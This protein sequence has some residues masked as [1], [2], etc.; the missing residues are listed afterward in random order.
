LE[1]SILEA[2][3]NEHI[4]LCAGIINNGGLVAFPTE[5]VYGLGANAFDENAVSEIFRIKGR[6]QDNP[7]I[8]HV[9]S[10][11]EVEVLV[12]DTPGTFRIIAEAF[13]PGPLT[14]V[15]KKNAN[16]P[17]ITTA[18]LDIVAIRMPEHPAALALIRAC[19]KPLA[20][21]SA[22]PSGKPSPTKAR[23]VMNDLKGKI[24]YILDGGDCRVG[25]ESTVLD[26]VNKRPRIL[27]PGGVTY[28]ELRDVLSDVE[29]ASPV[30]DKT[31]RSP[32]MKYRHYAPKA[33]L[34]VVLGPPGVTAEYIKGQMS[35][36]TAALMFDD[37]RLDDPSVVTFGP[38]TDLSTQ[39]NRLFGALRKLDN[40]D[41]SVIYAQSP[42]EK[43]I[44]RAIANRIKKAAGDNVVDL[45]SKHL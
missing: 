24:P 6:Q 14:L 42:D 11:N 3:N 22:N 7:L 18:G 13:W 1:T 37:Y 5:T 16:I 44:G 12:K 38:S 32:G 29:A 41:I 15:M 34:T 26:L 36:K 17:M 27:R 23:H 35:S 28:E 43:G 40:M 25:L 8:V 30:L 31:P 10:L 45:R 2:S 21:P 39:A 33:P 19:G 4:K 20:A 9:A